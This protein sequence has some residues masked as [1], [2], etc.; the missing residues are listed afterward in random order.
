MTKCKVGPS[1]PNRCGSRSNSRSRIRR[2]RSRAKKYRS[3]ESIGI[4]TTKAPFTG[5]SQILAHWSSS[6]NEL[7][8]KVK[9]YKYHAQC[10]RTK[11]TWYLV[12]WKKESWHRNFA[13]ATDWAASSDS[14]PYTWTNHLLML[15]SLVARAEESYCSF[16][17]TPP[18]TASSQAIAKLCHA[19]PGG[20]VSRTCRWN[21]ANIH[22]F[23]ISNRTFRPG[24]LASSF[25]SSIMEN[26]PLESAGYW[27]DVYPS[28]ASFLNWRS[29]QGLWISC[30]LYMS[31]IA[32]CTLPLRN[33]EWFHDN[34][35]LVTCNLLNLR[36]EPTR[37]RLQHAQSLDWNEPI[38]YFPINCFSSLLS[39]LYSLQILQFRP[40][41]LYHPISI[42]IPAT[43]PIYD[44]LGIIQVDIE[45]SRSEW[46]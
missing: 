40:I 8:G 46:S 15:L 34:R 37:S 42:Y 43:S 3:T 13:L 36:I 18:C 20:V 6:A 2:F 28:D 44:H 27:L 41:S 38:E 31:Y 25:S 9:Q 14:V 21:E 7:L 12:L 35:H 5:P 1:L 11:S 24:P 19:Q 26:M 39:G 22:S 45:V 10:L 29:T 32:S 4:R 23:R 17:G 16:K 33:L 30:W